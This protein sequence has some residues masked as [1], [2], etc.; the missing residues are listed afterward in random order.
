[1]GRPS[2][3]QNSILQS[4]QWDR[5]QQIVSAILC[6]PPCFSLSYQC[7]TMDTGLD[8]HT[9]TSGRWLRRD[10]LEHNSRYIMFDFDALC[11]RD[12]ELCPGAVSIVT[13]DK[14]EG[15]FNRVFIFTTDNAKLVVARLPFA[16]AGPRRFTTDSEVATIKYR[17]FKSIYLIEVQCKSLTILCVL[18]QANT[19]IPIPKILDWSGDAS[20]AIGSEYIIMEHAAGVQLHQRW[21]DM[22]GDQ[23]IRCIDAIY[24]KVKEMV[25]VKFPAYGSLYFVDAPLNSASKQPL[26]QKFCIGPHCGAMYWNCNVG[27]SRYYHNTKPNQGPCKF[28]GPCP[29]RPKR[30]TYK[31]TQ[32][33]ILTHIV[34]VSLIRVFSGS[35]RSIL[36]FGTDPAIMDPFRRTFASW[37]PVAPL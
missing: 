16:L 35:R 18:V 5:C 37:N 28:R 4:R 26:D 21:P 1:M 29:L 31:S 34:T 17:E 15:G 13:Y 32:G 11:R 12:V 33:L 20:N 9:Y 24:R 23:Q 2:I 7:T 6:S 8:P 25:D 10:K 3:A 14:K 22:S 30:T 36:Y 27:E 19:S